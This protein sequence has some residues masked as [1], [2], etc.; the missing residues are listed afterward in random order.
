[1]KRMALILKLTEYC[2]N[3]RCDDCPL[4]DE[5]SCTFFNLHKSKLKKMLEK[6]EEG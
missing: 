5:P 3:N 2:T 1:M 4:N 6:F